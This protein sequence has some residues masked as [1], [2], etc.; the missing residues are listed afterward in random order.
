MKWLVSKLLRQLVI[1]VA[2]FLMFEEWLWEKLSNLIG[3]MDRR[4]G[5]ARVEARLARVRPSVALVVFLLPI[6]VVIPVKVVGLALLAKGKVLA[7]MSVLLAAKLVGVGLFARIFNVTRGQLL[8]LPW[9]A[10]VHAIVLGW[11][12]RAHE[13][14][15]QLPAV[16]RLR[17]STGRFKS[18]FKERVARRRAIFARR[19]DAARR[20]MNNR[21]TG[22]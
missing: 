3:W 9:F 22:L 4:L 6:L 7:S 13:W 8:Q 15:D 16:I 10:W 2:L 19:I 14:F 17:A 21:S 18:G 5:L 1:A 11:L 20:W 12:A